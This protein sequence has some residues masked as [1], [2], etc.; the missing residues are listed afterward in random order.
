[1]TKQTA[2]QKIIAAMQEA[3]A[4]DVV[5]YKVS[6]SPKEVNIRE[7]R[8]ELGMN[9]EQFAQAFQFSPYSVR[10]WELG[11]RQPSGAALAFLQVI[12]AGPLDAYQKLHP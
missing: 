6:R 12:Q 9:R 1:M 4:G 2:G 3:L 10:N 5:T 7:V 11:K 8:E